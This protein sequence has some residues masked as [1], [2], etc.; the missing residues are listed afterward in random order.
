MHVSK[1]VIYQDVDE[2][3]A[4]I[5]SSLTGAVDLLDSRGKAA[6]LALEASDKTDGLDKKFMARLRK[7][8]YVYHSADEET[9]LFNELAA[10]FQ[11]SA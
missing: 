5:A 6:W 7:R 2:D 4:L 10:A 11:S 8:G 9:H 1:Y 3:H